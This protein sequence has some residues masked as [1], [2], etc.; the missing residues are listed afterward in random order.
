MTLL[1]G[2]WDHEP[3]EVFRGPWN[4]IDSGITLK[5]PLLFVGNTGDPVTP[6]A[7][8]RKMVDLF[9]NSAALLHHNGYGHCSS[10]QPSMCTAKAIRAYLLDGTLP[11]EN[12]V[13]E[14]DG[15]CVYSVATS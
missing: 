5:H 14:P 3:V 15:E 12:L 2:F 4:T 13:C 6:L 9:P 1:V 11:D 7:S 10:A 8:A